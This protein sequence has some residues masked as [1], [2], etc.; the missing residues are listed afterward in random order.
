MPLKTLPNG[1]NIYT[2]IELEYISTAA[3]ILKEVRA[4]LLEFISPGVSTAEIDSL[5]EKLIYQAG[6]EPL[7]KGFEGY[8][9][10]TCLSANE[11]IVHG[12]PTSHLLREGDILSLDLGVRYKGYC[13]DSARTLVVGGGVS[14][15]QSLIDVAE[16]AFSEALKKAVP[17]STTGTIG[18]TIHKEVLRELNIPGKW[19]SG[20]KFKIFSQFQ[21]H[22]IGLN[23]HESPPVPNLGSIGKGDVLLPGMCICIEP[24]VLYSSSNVIKSYENGILQFTTDNFLPSSHY[25]NQVFITDNGP[26]VLT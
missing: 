8:P 5:A 6:G 9:F 24:V 23:L 14:P 2:S 15:H 11:H 3:V 7:F 4:K 13:S 19:A 22:G 21:G 20:H 12:L 18:F 1:A 16:T 26:L 10:S 17:Q 25:E